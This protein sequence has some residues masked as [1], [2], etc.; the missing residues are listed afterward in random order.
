[1]K[2]IYVPCSDEQEAK[3]IGRTLVEEKLAVCANIL[4]ITSIYPWENEIREDSESLLLLKTNADYETVKNRIEELHSYE[5]P[6][7]SELDIKTNKKY[8]D[9][10]NSL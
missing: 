1:M 7:I 8:L 4:P 9:W 3:K 6:A 5:I 10:A 2:L